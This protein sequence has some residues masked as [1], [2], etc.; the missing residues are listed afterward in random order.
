MTSYG[1]WYPDTV[2]DVYEGNQVYTFT[3]DESSYFGYETEEPG[4]RQSFIP[5]IDKFYKNLSLSI[6][7]ENMPIIS[8]FFSIGFIFWIFI[9]G[10]GYIVRNGGF[11]AIVPYTMPAMTMATLLLGPTYLPRYVFFLWLC[12]PFVFGNM[13]FERNLVA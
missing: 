3:Y 6:F 10:I 12:L 13:V 2:V 8:M 11:M 5:A 7:K 9:L 4:V 1:Y